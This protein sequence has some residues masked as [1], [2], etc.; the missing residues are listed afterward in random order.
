VA[1]LYASALERLTPSVAAEFATPY[2]LGPDLVTGEVDHFALGFETV[3]L[4]YTFLHEGAFGHGGAAG[5]MGWADPESRVA[6]GYV[7]RRFGYP[8]AENERLGAAVM[9]AART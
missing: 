1:R 8:G 9:T 7:R 5:A 3:S 2:S 6:Y 4:K